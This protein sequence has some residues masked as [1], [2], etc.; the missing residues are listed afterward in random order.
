MPFFRFDTE[1]NSGNPHWPGIES[2]GADI[3]IAYSTNTNSIGIGDIKQFSYAGQRPIMEVGD[4][5]RI[6]SISSTVKG[7]MLGVVTSYSYAP[8]G[9]ISTISVDVYQFGGEGVSSQWEIRQQLYGGINVIQTPGT[10]YLAKL[11]VWDY[12]NNGGGIALFGF[13]NDQ[14]SE[15]VQTVNTDAQKAGY[16]RTTYKGRVRVVEDMSDLHKPWL[17]T[18]VTATGVLNTTTTVQTWTYPENPEYPPTR[19]ETITRESENVSHTHTFTDSDF[20]PDSPGWQPG[21]GHYPSVC[22]NFTA[23]QL[24]EY[25]TTYVENYAVIYPAI[26]PNAWYIIN[27]TIVYKEILDSKITD[28]QPAGFF[29]PPGM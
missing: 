22:D 12:Q 24:G 21:V 26:D 28:V 13:P 27:S 5:I 11:S 2:Y 1:D 15:T 29:T 17:N 20:S 23:E 14:Q 4:A 8:G 16:T 9:N 7:Y 10:P 6:D 18:L 25:T 19:T 3:Y